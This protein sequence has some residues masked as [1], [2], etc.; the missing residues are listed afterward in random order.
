LLAAQLYQ[1][2]WQAGED[3][4]NQAF[5]TAA[6]SLPPASVQFSQRFGGLG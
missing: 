3:Y 6:G 4:I 5:E 2:L 1:Q